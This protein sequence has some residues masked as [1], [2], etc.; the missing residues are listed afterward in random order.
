M[1]NELQLY[2]RS[3]L[4][5]TGECASSF[6]CGVGVGGNGNQQQQWQTQVY[7]PSTNVTPHHHHH[8]NNHSQ[9]NG[10]VATGIGLNGSVGNF[11][12]FS[13]CRSTVPPPG[14]GRLQKSLSF[15][16]QTPSAMMNEIWQQQPNCQNQLS[17]INYPP[18]RSHSR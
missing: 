3:I 6:R 13:N 2:L 8:Y 15:A 1:I 18:Q 16:F 10:V 12:Q 5:R 14:H 9:Q 4:S 11:N 17:S 7:Y